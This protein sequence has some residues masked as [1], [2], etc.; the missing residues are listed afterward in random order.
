MDQYTIDLTGEMLMFGVLSKL[1]Y[2][3]PQMDWIQSLLV[4]KVFEEVPFGADQ[5]DVVNGMGLIQVW[6]QSVW[7]LNPQAALAELE[8]D[9]LCLFIGA[10]KVMAPPWE[11]VYFS[12]ERLLFREQTLQVRQWYRRYGLESEQLYHEPDDHIGLELSFMA[13]LTSLALQARDE[14]KL[15]EFDEYLTAQKEFFSNHL[16]K[17]GPA[18]AKL[19]IEHAQTDFYRGIGHLTLGSLLAVAHLLQLEIPEK[20]LG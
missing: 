3:S 11:S 6:N 13:H 19:V 1:L 16:L 8:S 20:A 4:E 14:N 17:W 5:E 15:A 7:N 2:T 9:Y 18:W 12:Q 10:G